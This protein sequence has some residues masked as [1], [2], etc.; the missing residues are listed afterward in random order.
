MDR[1]GGGQEVS[2]H[3]PQRGGFPRTVGAEKAHDFTPRNSEA[4]IID[5]TDL[6]EMLRQ[7]FNPDH[8]PIL[9]QAVYHLQAMNTIAGFKKTPA[10]PVHFRG[11]AGV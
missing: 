10:H 3:H 4:D 11:W 6:P 1:P 8:I 5:G 9:A 7:I 2:R